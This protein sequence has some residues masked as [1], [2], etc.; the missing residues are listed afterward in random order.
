MESIYLF[1]LVSTGGL[2]FLT[3]M[4]GLFTSVEMVENIDLEHDYDVTH[5]HTHEI[6]AWVPFFSFRFWL[7]AGFLYGLSGFLLPYFEWN[8]GSLDQHWVPILF[9]L[10]GGWV[11]HLVMIQVTMNQSSSHYNMSDLIGNEAEVLV[12][13]SKLETG[14][15]IVQKESG[16][17]HFMAISEEDTF[18]VGEKVVIKK[19]NDSATFIVEKKEGD[20]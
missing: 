15:I 10:F 14:K 13:I 20:K 9:G 2:I 3:S 12:P 11:V 18:L 16:R 1:L 17:I 4:K 8:S 19:L 7:Y 5:D 6:P